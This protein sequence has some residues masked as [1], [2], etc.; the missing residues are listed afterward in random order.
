MG[1]CLGCYLTHFY[2]DVK[3]SEKEGVNALFAAF[4]REEFEY[5]RNQGA[6]EIKRHSRKKKHLRQVAG[7]KR[8]N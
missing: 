8:R 4:D 1:D 3:R 2:Q 7:Q 5:L 6:L